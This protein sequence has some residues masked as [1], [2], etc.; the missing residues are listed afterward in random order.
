M[1]D[2]SVIIPVYNVGKHLRRCLDSIIKQRYPNYEIIL[3]DDGSTDES[4]KICD[5]Y[6]LHNNKIRVFHQE[7]RG[8]SEARNK[9]LNV[10]KG[11]YIVFVDSDDE[12]TEN[13]L[14]N[15]MRIDESVDIVIS[16]VRN[17]VNMLTHHQLQ[18]ET[19]KITNLQTEDILNMSSDKSLNFIYAKR[20]KK[21]LIQK[22]H[23]QF[24]PTINLGEDTLFVAEYSLYSNTI[25]YISNVD[26]YYYY[27]YET[28]TL[29]SIDEKYVEKLDMVNEVIAN[30]LEE[31]YYG[32]KDSVEWNNRCFSVYHYMIFFVLQNSQYTYREK[33]SMLSE[34]LKRKKFKVYRKYLNVYMEDE[35]WIIQKLIYTSNPEVIINGYNAICAIQ[36]LKL[37]IR[38][39]LCDKKEV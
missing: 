21:S 33:N 22:H 34:I 25:Q 31:K 11:K 16:G 37:K 28:V 35:S 2:V 5:E 36:N 8:V 18:Y 27:K 32:I 20:F 38:G 30:T 7:N 39:R 19:K 23:I 26:Y 29:S 1:V 4:G 14:W 15:M 17:I 13:Y 12:V 24:N 9:G 10:A 3:V 6:A